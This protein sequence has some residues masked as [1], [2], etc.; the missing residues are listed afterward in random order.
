ME[1]SLPKLAANSSGWGLNLPKSECEIDYTEC[2]DELDYV[3]LIRRRK[4]LL[5]SK[6]KPT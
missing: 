5:A 1:E 2:S 6:Q 4:L 3:P